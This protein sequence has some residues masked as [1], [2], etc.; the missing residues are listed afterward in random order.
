VP[1]YKKKPPV[2]EATQWFR[3]G[4]HPADQSKPIER[5][6]EPPS[7]S[8]GAVV[9]FF[10]MFHIPGDRYCS[11]C[12]SQMNKHGIIV[13]LNGEDEL[14]HPGDYILTHAKGYFYR[15]GREEFENGWELI[16]EV[17]TDGDPAG[18][19]A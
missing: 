14:V 11:T 3:N 10:N 5:P 17:V 2:V 15:V 9:K 16:E 12:G 1:R 8:E 13:N 6:N 7:L 4:D 18:R 19:S